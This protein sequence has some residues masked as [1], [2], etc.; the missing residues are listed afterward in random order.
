MIAYIVRRV[1]YA[2]PILLG[3][4]IFTF[5]LFF[6]VNT[7]DDMA[8][9]CLGEK[10]I[11]EDQIAQWK[12]ERGYHLPYFYNDGWTEISVRQVVEE[13]VKFNQG[14]L[15]PGEYRL[16]VR[17]SGTGGALTVS[18]T[19]DSL[20]ATS[21]PDRWEPELSQDGQSLDF[22]ISAVSAGA[23]SEPGATSSTGASPLAESRWKI[24]CPTGTVS[25]GSARSFV[26]TPSAGAGISTVAL[27][28]IT[29]TT[30]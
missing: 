12:R 24:T 6:F 9:V 22:S 4:N 23:G 27:S 28:V 11:T 16:T 5:V 8:R 14:A 20:T 19:P 3:V 25:P 2:I 17:S 18:I 21:F 26:T 1:L 15:R 29:S 10:R 7:P 13:E 30:D